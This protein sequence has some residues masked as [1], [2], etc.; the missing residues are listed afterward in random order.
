MLSTSFIVM[1]IFFRGKGQESGTRKMSHIHSYLVFYQREKR[2]YIYV[3]E[4]RNSTFFY[5]S[6]IIK[7]FAANNNSREISISF[8]FLD[9]IFYSPT[10]FL[11]LDILEWRRSYA[12]CH[13]CPFFA[14]KVIKLRTMKFSN[15]SE[16]VVVQ[17]I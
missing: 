16:L 5:W 2:T 1:I 14:A 17:K 3:Q 6:K 4:I 11:N 8:F 7:I 12:K 10:L 9:Q 13:N 15:F